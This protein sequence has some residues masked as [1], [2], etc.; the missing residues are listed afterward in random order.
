MTPNTAAVPNI[1]QLKQA[2]TSLGTWNAAIH[3]VSAFF[4]VPVHEDHQKQFAFRWQGQ[5]HTFRA[6]PQGY[7]NSPALCHNLFLEILIVCLFY[8]MSHTGPVYWWYINWTKWAGGSSC[9]DRV[10]NT[11]VPENECPWLI[12]M[13]WCPLS[14]WH[15]IGSSEKNVPQLREHLHNIRL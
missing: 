10:D 7:I 2:N 4:S 14:S 6:L 3:L 12:P 11:Y 8:K 5:Q 1:A 13:T 15:E 9:S